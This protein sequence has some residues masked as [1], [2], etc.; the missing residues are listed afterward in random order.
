MR[1]MN[2]FAA[3]V[4][5]LFNGYNAAATRFKSLGSKSVY[6]TACTDLHLDYKRV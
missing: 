2:V 4:R 3:T 6:L 1:D 5:V